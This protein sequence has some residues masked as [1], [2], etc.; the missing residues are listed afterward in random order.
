MYVKKGVAAE[1]RIDHFHTLNEILSKYCPSDI[2]DVW[3]EKP[4][5]QIQLAYKFEIKVWKY[6]C[7]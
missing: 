5:K 4:T 7:R 2:V 3:K 6:R 1:C